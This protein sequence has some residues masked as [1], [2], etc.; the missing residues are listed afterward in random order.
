MKNL[1]LLG[2]AA[3]LPLGDHAAGFTMPHM[4]K[5]GRNDYSR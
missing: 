3:A 5:N 1:A 4:A 2:L